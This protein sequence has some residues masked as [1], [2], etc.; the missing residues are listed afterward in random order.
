MAAGS[1]LGWNLSR[2]GFWLLL[3]RFF[4]RKSLF[5]RARRAAFASGRSADALRAGRGKRDVLARVA[6]FAI[7]TRTLLLRLIPDVA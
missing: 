7:P 1:A 6:R 4:K 3:F 5:E 2:W